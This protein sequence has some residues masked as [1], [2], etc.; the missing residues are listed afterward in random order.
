M[1]QDIY[2]LS[3]IQ[4]YPIGFK[5]PIK[6]PLD[7]RSFYYGKASGA[8]DTG[9]GAKSIVPQLV[10]FATINAPADAGEVLLAIDV[11]LTDGAEGD[12]VIGEDELAGGYLVL[13]TPAPMQAYNRRIVANTATTGAGGVTIM[14]V[15]IDKPFPIDVVVANFHAECM[16]NPYVG[17][18]TGNYPAA[19]VVGMPTMQATLALPYLWLQTWGPVWVT[20]SNNEGIGLSNREVCFMG[21]GAISAI[22]V[23]NQNYSHQAQRAGFVLPNLRD[24]SEGAPF[25]FLQITP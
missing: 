3:A 22:D 11:A 2:E 23:A 6:N 19:S 16:A 18:R 25:I 17:V 14:V 8:L 13:F 20:P 9:Y 24:G 4:R 10:P 21:N 7:L 15:T 5:Y 12:G 1:K